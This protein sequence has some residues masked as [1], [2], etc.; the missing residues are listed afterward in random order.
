MKR[1]IDYF[2]Y[3]KPLL[4]LLMIP[5]AW[6]ALAKAKQMENG[7]TIYL[8]NIGAIFIALFVLLIARWWLESKERGALFKIGVLDLMGDMAIFV[9]CYTATFTTSW[10][11]TGAGILLAT[12]NL[13]RILKYRIYNDIYLHKRYREGSQKYARP[14]EPVHA[15]LRGVLDHLPRSYLYT[16]YSF[17]IF[18]MLSMN[19]PLYGTH[20][21]DAFQAL[22]PS[23]NPLVDFVYFNIVTL[24]TVGYGDMSPVSALAKLTC[25]IEILFGLMV[26]AAIFTMMMG[27][28]QSI[29]G[30][31]RDRDVDDKPV[32]RVRS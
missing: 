30:Q 2:N 15:L 7:L 21:D 9:I 11:P 4:F 13:A 23:G 28:F 6:L 25:S 16:A 10:V 17:A 18:Q 26:L 22:S 31:E 14:G 32:G 29:A 5:L 27:K 1:R 20:S 8:T 24:A 3:S 12:F 19:N